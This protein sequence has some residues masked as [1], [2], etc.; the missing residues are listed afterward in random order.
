[1][2]D[3][4]EKSV[5]DVKDK[6]AYTNRDSR[7]FKVLFPK[8]ELE[9][10]PNFESAK[11][12]RVKS[13][14]NIS[15]ENK[16]DKHLTSCRPVTARPSAAENNKEKIKL[17]LNQLEKL[18]STKITDLNKENETAK[19]S[20]KDKL[21]MKILDVKKQKISQNITPNSNQN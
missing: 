8:E 12:S 18:K 17:Y 16:K 15:A 1:M 2:F 11:R 3:R 13:T 14:E 9:N 10:M 4:Q 6:G 7:D 19:N 5:T 21:R 20:N